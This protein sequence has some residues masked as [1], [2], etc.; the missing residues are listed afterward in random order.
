MYIR[1]IAAINPLL[2]WVSLFL[3]CKL[4]ASRKNAECL[5]LPIPPLCLYSAYML[6]YLFTLRITAL[7]LTHLFNSRH[8]SAGLTGL[9][10]TTLAWVSGF[11]V[12]EQQLG[13]WVSWLK[14]VSPQY[15]M[16][17]PIT[18]GEFG[19]VNVLRYR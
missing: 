10:F 5:F 7:S 9:L 14:Y 18:Q 16:S 17:H 12:H 1:Q 11:A 8:L 2:E 13:V 6:L 19:P 15:W 3:F 4:C